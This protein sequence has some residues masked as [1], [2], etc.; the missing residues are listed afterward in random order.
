MYKIRVLSIKGNFMKRFLIITLM[1][2]NLLTTQ[3]SASYDYIE[4]NNTLISCSQI[5]N[6]T[7][8]PAISVFKELG[9][10]SY[11]SYNKRLFI[12]SK[13]DQEL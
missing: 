1:S 11:Y 2:I 12:I 4:L 5:N 10:D 3:I 9:Y 7:Y 6:T 13:S 8:C